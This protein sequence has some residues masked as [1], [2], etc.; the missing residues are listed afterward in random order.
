M[1]NAIKAAGLAGILA[2]VLA[3]AAPASSTNQPDRTLR[4]GQAIETR[5]DATTSAITYWVSET[6][7]WHVVT[8]VD[9]VIG[10][11]S[12]TERHA[13]V[14]FTSVLLPGRPDRG[15]AGARRFGLT[16]K[17]QTAGRCT[18]VEIKLLGLRGCGVCRTGLDRHYKD[19]RHFVGA[20]WAGHLVADGR[21]RFQE[22]RDRQGVRPGQGGEAPPGHG[23]REQASVRALSF[24]NRGDDLLCGPVPE[25]A[26]LV[27]GQDGRGSGLRYGNRC[28]RQVRPGTCHVPL[29]GRPRAR[30]RPDGQ[31][32]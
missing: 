5:L 11:D 27:Q 18:R 8:T 1:A 6:D 17:P 12:D 3:T 20:E 22:R 16:V 14:R 9:A 28:N 31:R 29:A 25:A 19:G 7:G 13:V 23:R 26:L 10:R 24:S 21:Q 4:Q 30:T 2:A 32:R 15:G